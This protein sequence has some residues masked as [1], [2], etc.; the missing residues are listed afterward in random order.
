MCGGG[1]SRGFAGGVS[2]ESADVCD[3]DGDRDFRSLRGDGAR[4]AAAAMEAREGVRANRDDAACRLRGRAV[5][6]LAVAAL[7]AGVT[8]G[9]PQR[10]RPADIP[11]FP[12]P[13][14]RSFAP[15]RAFAETLHPALNAYAAYHPQ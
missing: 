15:K 3:A 4:A 12:A 1:F 5:A 6:K 14:S 7:H 11:K 10:R 13:L 9:D 8:R 2:R